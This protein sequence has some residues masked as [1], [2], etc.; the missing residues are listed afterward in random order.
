MNANNKLKFVFTT[1]AF[2]LLRFGFSDVVRT[3]AHQMF[4]FALRANANRD[5]LI[6]VGIQFEKVR[7]AFAFDVSKVIN[8]VFVLCAVPGQFLAKVSVIVPIPIATTFRE[9]HRFSDAE[10]SHSPGRSG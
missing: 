3:V 4:V 1:F 7:A 6:L 8:G 10:R 9:S 2:V 5:A